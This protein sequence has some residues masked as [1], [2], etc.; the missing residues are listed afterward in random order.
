METDEDD[1]LPRTTPHIQPST[2]C[3]LDELVV[4]DRVER[5][6]DIVEGDSMLAVDLPD[7]VLD[8]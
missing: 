7:D 1:A 4:E 6:L 3:V 5:V 2:A 8:Y